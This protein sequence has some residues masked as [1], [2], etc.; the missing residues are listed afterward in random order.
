MHRFLVAA[1]IAA[2]SAP[3]AAA[4]AALVTTQLPRSVVPVHYDVS[5]TPD[6]ANLRFAGNVVVTINVLEPVKS[7]TLNAADLTFHKASLSGV[8]EVP[9]ITTDA[10]AQTARTVALKRAASKRRGV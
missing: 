1:A 9:K 8:A 4:P 2:L 5:I 6:A 7:I 10:A 3:V